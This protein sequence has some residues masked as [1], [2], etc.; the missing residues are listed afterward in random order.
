MATTMLVET[1]PFAYTF[2]MRASP[3]DVLLPSKSPLVTSSIA[4]RSTLMSVRAFP[5]AGFEKILGHEWIQFLR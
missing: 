2:K 3:V 1:E 4:T 5:H